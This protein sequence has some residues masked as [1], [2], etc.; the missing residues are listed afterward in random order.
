[1]TSFMCHFIGPL[2]LGV[3]EIHE[4][5]PWFAWSSDVFGFIAV[6]GTWLA[7]PRGVHSAGKSCFRFGS[8]AVFRK[9]PCRRTLHT[10]VQVALGCVSESGIAESEIHLSWVTQLHQFLQLLH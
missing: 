8:V 3:C 1:M 5:E 4:I 2:F 7:V 10:R 9:R 6:S